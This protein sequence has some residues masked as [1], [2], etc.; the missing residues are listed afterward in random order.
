MTAEFKKSRKSHILTCTLLV[1]RLIKPSERSANQGRVQSLAYSMI[2]NLTQEI[3]T[4][5]ENCVENVKQLNETSG[6]WTYF[7]N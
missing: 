3:N 2:V 1:E 5:F 4:R 7:L 6:L